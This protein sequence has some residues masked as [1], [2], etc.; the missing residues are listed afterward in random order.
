MKIKFQADAD[1][2]QNIVNAVIR[3]NSEINF[4]TATN[5]NLRGLKD[6]KVLELAANQ[7][8]ILV[9]HDQRTMPTHFSK[10]LEENNKSYGV[11]IV[12]KRLSIMDVTEDIIL[13]WEACTKQDWI[14]RIHFLP[15]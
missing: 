14:D 8:R 7:K 1:L 10:F 4:Q 13:I 12:P 6:D 3:I 5:A 11:V 15:L 2:N 9:S